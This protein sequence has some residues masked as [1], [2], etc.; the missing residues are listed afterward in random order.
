MSIKF[1]IVIPTFSPTKELAD[2]ATELC[3]TV[4][5]QCDELIVCEDTE[6]YWPELQQACDVHV[7]HENWGFTKN[8]NTGLRLAQG[9][10][11]AIVNSDV[12]LLQGNFRDLCIPDQVT[13]PIPVDGWWNGELYG[14]CFCI[15]RTILEKHGYLNEQ[16][17]HFHSDVDYSNRIRNYLYPC[18]GVKI[19]HPGGASYKYR[20]EVMKLP[21]V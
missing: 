16:Y 7:I 2:M 14:G 5:P 4:K 3:K 21:D 19:S 1:S 6:N 18:N 8:V 17:K 9:D 13:M 10:F 12:K 20:R 15:P 11:V